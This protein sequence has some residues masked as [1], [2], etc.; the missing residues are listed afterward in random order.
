VSGPSLAPAVIVRAAAWPIESLNGFGD[1]EL[2]RMAAAA[3][4]DLATEWDAYVERYGR[5]LAQERAALRRATV[6]DPRFLNALAVTNPDAVSAA[7]R[8]DLD[9]ERTRRVRQLERTLYR[10]LSRAVGRTEPCDLW[11]GVALASWSEVTRIESERARYRFAPDLRPF[12]TMLRTLAQRPGYRAR[13]RWRVNPTLAQRAGGAWT[14][15]ARTGQ[16]AIVPHRVELGGAAAPA[17]RSLQHAR[18]ATLAELSRRLSADVELPPH[19]ICAL[20]ERL[21]DAG[22]LVGGLD[23][24]S[25]FA[26][27]WQALT[28]S[29][30][31]L[32]GVDRELWRAA[33]SDIRRICQTLERRFDRIMTDA[34]QHELNRVRH[35]IGELAQGLGIDGLELPRAI[36]RC[37]L[38]LP[39]RCEL[40][41]AFRAD[42]A[43]A[44]EAYDRYQVAIGLSPLAREM[45]AAK[46]RRQ[47]GTAMPIADAGEGWRGPP[48]AARPATWEDLLQP[49]ALEPRAASRLATWT[50]IVSQAVREVVLHDE[51]DLNAGL[52]L[53]DELSLNAGLGLH[54]EH[55]PHGAVA[56]ADSGSSSALRSPFGCL[57]VRPY[58]GPGCQAGLAIQGMLDEVTPLYARYAPLW[59]ANARKPQD[60]LYGW[61][62]DALEALGTRVGAEIVELVGPFEPNPNVLARPRF[63]SRAVEIW[64]ATPGMRS[65]VNAEMQVDVDSGR[66]IARLPRVARPVLVFGFSSA[67]IGTTDPFAALLMRS[68]LRGGPGGQFDASSLAFACEI[69][70]P[71]LAPRVR[72]PSGPVVRPHRIV[73]AGKTLRTLLGGADAHRFAAWQ[74][75]AVQHDLPPL[76]TVQRDGDLPLVLVRDSPLAFEAVLKGVDEAT[77][78]LTLDELTP[79]PWL[80]DG[81]GKHYLAELAV[82]FLR[83]DVVR[84]DAA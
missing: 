16:G 67:D 60:P 6:Q 54:A 58:R 59:N 2:A 81:E 37:D 33:V 50:R 82:P 69:T 20:L 30:R 9:G 14:F 7:R 22:I 21:A 39:I 44:V 23:L 51:R 74:A 49:D 57:R 40:G 28:Q 55:D 18:P 47:I 45:E 76:M 46:F 73:L 8:V 13:A 15:S 29:S 19:A 72:L 56:L 43:N 27:P 17:I 64:S 24:P 42:L 26:T 78:S 53:H 84:A 63:A 62:L 25:R 65:I 32:V 35:R 3:T 68:S 70:N 12:Q 48:G 52:A 77:R 66:T 75:L 1:G 79:T 5:V 80:Q 41:E 38:R 10:Y 4:P 36:V 61:T 71:Q 31:Q 11:A 83:S 34:L